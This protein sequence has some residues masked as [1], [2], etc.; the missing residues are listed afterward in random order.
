LVRYAIGLLEKEGLV[1]LVSRSGVYVTK[2]TQKEIQDIF[3][4]RKLLE[5][6]SLKTAFHNIT[7]RDL[8]A[9]EEKIRFTE[10]E[11][12]KGELEK[13]YEFDVALHQLIID[14]GQNNQIKKIY[15]NYRSI[16]GVI[17]FSDYNEFNFVLDSFKEH[18]KIFRAIR[19]NN[20]EMTEE[21]LLAHLDKSKA[22]VIQM[23]EKQIAD[24]N[25]NMNTGALPNLKV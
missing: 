21:L 5:S 9:I 4:V 22:R 17:I 13:S 16:V 7:R 15:A 18:C 24:M 19:D 1:E 8:E 14:R 3:E 6:F 2:F 12:K 11:F 25:V 10:E 20:P 23:F